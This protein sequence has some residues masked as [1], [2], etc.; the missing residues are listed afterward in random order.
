MIFLGHVVFGCGVDGG[1]VGGRR[2]GSAVI[3][4]APLN[5]ERVVIVDGFVV[6]VV[7]VTYVVVITCRVIDVV[8]VVDVDVVDVV[9][10]DVVV[11]VGV[12]VV[13]VGNGVGGVVFL[14]WN[15]DG[16]LFDVLEFAGDPETA[17][18]VVHHSTHRLDATMTSDLD[19]FTLKKGRKEKSW[20]KDDHKKK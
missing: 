18:S 17:F 6:V 5:G 8:V 9:V 16:F 4:A 20:V 11:V 7:V 15:D 3:A 13:D 14:G 1:G 2:R 19:D 10:V 12:D